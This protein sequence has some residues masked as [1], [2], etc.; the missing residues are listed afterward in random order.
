MAK[1][2]KG[3]AEKTAKSAKNTKIVCPV[4]GENIDYVKH[5]ET[6]SDP[7]KKSMRFKEKMVGICKCNHDQI[8]K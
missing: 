6:I 7:A 2:G 1:G 3:F 5:I 4:C 8:Y